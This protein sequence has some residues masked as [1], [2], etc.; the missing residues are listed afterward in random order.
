MVVWHCYD[1]VTLKHGVHHKCI[2]WCTLSPKIQTRTNYRTRIKQ[3]DSRL[4][5]EGT[6]AYQYTKNSEFRQM[7]ANFVEKKFVIFVSWN[8]LYF[9][10]GF[11]RI[12]F[13]I[14]GLSLKDEE[15][16][17]V[18][19]AWSF[20]FS[21]ILWDFFCKFIVLWELNFAKNSEILPFVLKFELT[22]HSSA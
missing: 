8:L 16:N 11:Q 12:F 6:F 14:F 2:H 7:K 4:K 17:F 21:F 20:F 18:N 15:Y 13:K 5:R 22:R 19:E 1:R 10:M 3:R 9:Q